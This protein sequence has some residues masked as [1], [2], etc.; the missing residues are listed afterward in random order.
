MPQ[1][2]YAI[3]LP[4]KILYDKEFSISAGTLYEINKTILKES[5]KVL[6]GKALTNAIDKSVNPFLKKYD[7]CSYLMLLSNDKRYYTIFHAAESNFNEEK[8]KETFKL[9]SL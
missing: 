8:C 5:K 2:Y 3:D 9:E 4:G 7:Y 6:R 1:E